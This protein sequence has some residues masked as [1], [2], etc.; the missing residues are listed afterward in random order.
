M[1]TAA[2]PDTLNDLQSYLNNRKRFSVDV[3]SPAPGTTIGFTLQDSTLALADNYPRGRLAE[4]FGVTTTT[5]SW[6]RIVLRRA[7]ILDPLVSNRNVNTLAILFNSGSVD[8]TTVFLDNIHGPR[9]RS[10]IISNVKENSSIG[11]FR[12]Y[13]VPASR[14]LNISFQSKLANSNVELQLVDALGRVVKS[15]TMTELNAGSNAQYKFSLNGLS[16]GIYQV[17]LKSANGLMTSRVI[18]K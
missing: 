14:E 17:N 16:A 9:F 2:I 10:S 1:I 11:E 7:S 18:V 8:A 6:E 13:P 12:C 5:N 4:F 3:Y 15:H